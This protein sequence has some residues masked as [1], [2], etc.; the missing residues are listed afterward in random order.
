MP[1]FRASTEENL[2]K[3][4]LT[5]SDRKYMVQT[6]AT[7]LMSYVSD[8]SL[9]HCGVAA[10][11]LISKFEFLKDGEGDGEVGICMYVKCLVCAH[12]IL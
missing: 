10:K 2:S 7:M 9:K 12:L 4:V 1:K 6:L 3:R 11:A 5:D 8:P